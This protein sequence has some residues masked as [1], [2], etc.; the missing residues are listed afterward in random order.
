MAGTCN[1]NRILSRAGKRNQL[2]AINF[3]R[4][5]VGARHSLPREENDGVTMPKVNG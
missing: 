3:Y 5:S 4:T 1:R 2:G